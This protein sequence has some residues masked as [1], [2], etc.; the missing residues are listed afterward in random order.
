MCTDFGMD[1]VQLCLTGKLKC[2]ETLIFVEAKLPP[3]GRFIDRDFI[4]TCQPA[5]RLLASRRLVGHRLI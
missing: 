3:T 1:G 2:H 4:F 5:N